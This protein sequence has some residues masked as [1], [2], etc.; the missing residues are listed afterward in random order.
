MWLCVIVLMC[1][2]CVV[3]DLAKCGYVLYVLM[4]YGVVLLVTLLSVVM[5]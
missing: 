5:C 4:C 1:W 3:G 2:C